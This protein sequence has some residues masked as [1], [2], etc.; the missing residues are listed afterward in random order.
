MSKARPHDRAEGVAVRHM[1]EMPVLPPPV[2][3]CCG[4][5]TRQRIE[6]RLLSASTEYAAFMLKSVDCPTY[7]P[8]PPCIVCGGNSITSRSRLDP[9]CETCEV[10]LRQPDGWWIRFL[11]WLQS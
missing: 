8:F 1:L 7:H 4:T 3:D 9:V 10:N 6:K 5:T 2:C 11:R